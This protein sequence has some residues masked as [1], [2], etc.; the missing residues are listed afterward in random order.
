[1]QLALPV[2]TER[3]FVPSG[4]E[5]SRA[6]SSAF[7]CFLSA[8]DCGI[9]SVRC[10]VEELGTGTVVACDG[11][12]I[13]GGGGVLTRACFF[14]PQPL[15]VTVTSATARA[16]ADGRHVSAAPTSPRPD[17]LPA[18]ISSRLRPVTPWSSVDGRLGLPR[19]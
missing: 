3:G 11:S 4:T 8:F 15:S 12:A 18:S 19:R 9:A 2:S 6:T 13:G 1:Y 14:P 10:G 16:Q 17:S 5:S 7:S